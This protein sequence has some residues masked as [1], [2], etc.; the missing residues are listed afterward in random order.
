MSTTFIS[1]EVK[2]NFNKKGRLEISEKEVQQD[3]FGVKHTVQSPKDQ[4]EYATLDEDQKKRLVNSCVA[5]LQR[6]LN[7]EG[8]TT[9]TA[10]DDE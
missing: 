4:H 9:T 6:F 1:S 10:F 5:L 8:R 2:F 7:S 3:E